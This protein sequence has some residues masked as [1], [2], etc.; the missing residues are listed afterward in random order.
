MGAQKIEHVGVTKRAQYLKMSKTTL[1]YTRNDDGHFVCPHCD[2]ITEKQNTMYYHVKKTHMKDLPYECKTCEDHPRFVQKSSY[3]QHLAT[4]HPE[5]KTCELGENPYTG[6]SHACAECDHS[7][8]TKANLLIHYARS[9]CKSWIPTYTKET[10]CTGCAK[11]FNSSSAYLYHSIGCL[12][13]SA[14]KDQA[15]IISRIK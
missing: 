6:V 15:I 9:H 7:T 5:E 3:F 4:H 10:A 13:R 14:P 11:T 2:K 8:H 1:K 12:L